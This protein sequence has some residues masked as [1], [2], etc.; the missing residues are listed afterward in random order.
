MRAV[1]RPRN[2]PSCGRPYNLVVLMK[3][4]LRTSSFRSSCD[5]KRTESRVTRNTNDLPAIRACVIQNF[6]EMT[7]R[8]TLNH[9]VFPSRPAR[10]AGR[11]DCED[12]R[13]AKDC[14]EK[15]AFE[16]D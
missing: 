3:G 11:T 6:L 9:T 7:H 16:V 2:Y 14:A 5:R 4:R 13:G 10:F 1:S 8:R 12:E 15:Y